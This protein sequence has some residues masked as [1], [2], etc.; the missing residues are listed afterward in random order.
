MSLVDA[1]SKFKPPRASRPWIIA[2]ALGAGSA[3][4]PAFA[5]P[6]ILSAGPMDLTVVVTESLVNNI[7][8]DDNKKAHDPLTGPLQS[9]DLLHLSNLGFNGSGRSTQ[10]T[11]AFGSAL[12]RSDANGGVGVSIVAERGLGIKH[13][14]FASSTFTQTFSYS[15]TV[16]SS[17][18][19]ALNI[20]ASRSV[21]STLPRSLQPFASL[22]ARRPRPNWKRRSCTPTAPAKPA[23]RFNS[24]CACSRRRSSSRQEPS[25]NS[26]K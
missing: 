26:P 10:I 8:F 14:L 22:R 1:N 6:S 5:D 11:Q 7:L 20:R 19:M 18:A 21:C 13:E 17:V 9:V 4:Q 25:R 24:G 3:A 15:G 23:G 12:A 2:L 16:A